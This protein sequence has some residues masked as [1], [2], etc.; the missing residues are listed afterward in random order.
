MATFDV[1]KAEV[2]KRLGNR[3]DIDER[4][5]VWINDAYF[6]LLMEPEFTFYELDFEFTIVTVADQRA[7]DLSGVNALWFILMMRDTTNEREVR[8]TSVKVIDRLATTTGQ[9]NRYA[10]FANT[11]LLDPIPDDVYSLN[12]RYRLRPNELIT[13]TS[14]VIGREWDEILVVLSTVKGYEAL[15]QPEKA[16]A[17]RTLLNPLIDGRKDQEILEDEDSEMGIRVRLRGTY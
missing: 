14:P 10:R 5:N 15:E 13:G 17:A 1:I 11:I 7:Y 6:E 9:P 3:Q 12:V 16:G 8:K 2:K 4:L